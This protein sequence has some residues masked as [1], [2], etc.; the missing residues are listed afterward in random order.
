MIDIKLKKCL[1]RKNTIANFH[2]CYDC[3]SLINPLEIH[4]FIIEGMFKDLNVC[5]DCKD[6]KG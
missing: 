2:S 1:C 3:G 6:K 4:Y 5:K